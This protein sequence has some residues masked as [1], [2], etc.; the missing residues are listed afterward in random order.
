MV[1]GDLD[2]AMREN[3]TRLCQG[4]GSLLMAM[5]CSCLTLSIRVS[6]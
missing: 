4:A 5:V 1:G 2:G 3:A 6:V